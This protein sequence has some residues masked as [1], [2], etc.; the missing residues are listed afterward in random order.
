MLNRDQIHYFIAEIVR[1]AE[2]WAKPEAR[3]DAFNEAIAHFASRA[4]NCPDQL[5]RHEA[6]MAVLMAL[7]DHYWG[8]AIGWY[9]MLCNG[10]NVEIVAKITTPSGEVKEIRL[11]HP[12]E[13]EVRGSQSDSGQAEQEPNQSAEDTPEGSGA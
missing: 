9:K 6:V 1:D 3:K 4:K 12:P 5:V 8:G 13:V 7:R 10:T 2:E 11:D